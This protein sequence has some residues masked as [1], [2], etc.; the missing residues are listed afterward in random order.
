[1]IL[2]AMATGLPI[3][4][5]DAT[6]GPD[7]ISMPGQGGWII[8][9]GEVEALEEAMRHCLARQDEMHAV[10]KVSRRLLNNIRQS[11]LER[12]FEQIQ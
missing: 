4:T 12:T 3:I 11:L 10:G 5:T 6:A 8:P 2:E 7:L 1:M 9:T